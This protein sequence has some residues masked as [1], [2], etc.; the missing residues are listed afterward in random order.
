MAEPSEGL[1]LGKVYNPSAVPILNRIARIVQECQ[2]QASSNIPMHNKHD[3]IRHRSYLVNLKGQ[4]EFALAEEPLDCPK[5]FPVAMPILKL[6]E[7]VPIQ[8]INSAEYCDHWRMVY[9]ELASSDTARAPGGWMP[10]DKVRYDSY[11]VYASKLLDK[12]ENEDLNPLDQPEST[13]SLPVQPRGQ[14]GI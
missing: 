3:L 6:P 4:G 5:Y 14:I 13:P 12:Y 1:Q 9:F 7:S 2:R 11:L 8:S 10:Y